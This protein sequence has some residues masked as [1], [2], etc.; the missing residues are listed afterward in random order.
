MTILDTI[1]Q[2]SIKIHHGLKSQKSSNIQYQSKTLFKLLKKARHTEFGMHYH[3][4]SI[5]KSKK[6]IAQFQQTIPYYQYNDMFENW[7]YK[8]YDGEKNIAWPG[9]VKY[10]ALSSGT[11]ASASKRIPVTKDMINQVKQI[12]MKQ[13]LSLHFFDIHPKIY[14]NDILMLG[15]STKLIQKGDVYEG[16]MSGISARKIP[17][18]V[19]YLFY[20]PGKKISKRT[21]WEDRINMIVKKA[22]QWN[23]AT[24]CGVP[25]WVEIVLE[26]IIEHHKLNS[27]HDIWPNFQLYI[28]GGVCFDPYKENFKTLLGKPTQFIETYMA[29][30][31]SFGFQARPNASGIQLVLNNGIF[32]EFVPFNE[33][34]FT[35]DGDILTS[36]KSFVI[37]EVKEKTPY[38]VVISTCAGAWRYLIGDVIEFTNAKNAEIKIVG[39]T[40][41]FLSLC[42]EH[43]SVDNMNQ[44]IIYTQQTLGISIKE[45]TV[46]GEKYNGKFAHYWF[47]GTEDTKY[48]E[49]EIKKVL[50]KHLCK[51]N[52]DYATERSSALPTL[53]LQKINNH[54]FN[55]Y[56]ELQGKVGGMV[57]FPR[58]LKGDRIKS[59]TNFLS[60]TTL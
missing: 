29:S 50:D 20:R 55:D 9:K 17:K 26:K 40:K 58:V 38:A 47:I 23:V 28:H 33:I 8:S 24:I 36:A 59:W 35:E 42:G 37:S 46:Y 13:L 1:I 6:Y 19:S 25:A 57:K 4:I 32:F 2:Q 45:F 53:F 18:W 44:A 7:W 5:L 30:E 31:G 21:L 52:D 34:N 12:G 48:T 15:G 54:L 51:I 27:I 22:P 39:R 41:Q 56:L 49:E 43:L 10:F 60:E 14:H 3:F 16:D 11:S